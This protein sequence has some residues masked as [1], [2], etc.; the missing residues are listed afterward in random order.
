MAA[1]LPALSV[2]ILE[3]A[4]EHGRVTTQAI[5]QATGES[6]STIKTRLKQLIEDRLL[7]RYG[8]TKG[9]NIFSWD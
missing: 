3:L 4:K 9:L 7:V 2:R 1:A 6:R 8:S 5:E